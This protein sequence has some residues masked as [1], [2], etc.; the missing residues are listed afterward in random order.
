MWKVDVSFVASRGCVD[1]QIEINQ[2][3]VGDDKEEVEDAVAKFI[4][5]FKTM[6]YVVYDLKTTYTNMSNGNKI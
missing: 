4:I 1:Q 2:T 6:G 3:L 5:S